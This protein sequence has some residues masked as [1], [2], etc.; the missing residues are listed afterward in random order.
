M[1]VFLLILGGVSLI[2][3]ESAGWAGAVMLLSWSVAYQ[4]SVRFSLYAIANLY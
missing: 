2:P 1:F 3:G 4:F